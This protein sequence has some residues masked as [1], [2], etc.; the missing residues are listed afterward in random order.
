MM[1][2]CRSRNDGRRC[3]RELDHRGLHRHRMIMWT[4]AGA[5]DPRCRG[6]G[7]RGTVA[8][9][10]SNGFPGGRAVCPDCLG[11]VALGADG[12]LV[13]H[14]TAS[15]ASEEEAVERAEWFNTHGWTESGTGP[16]RQPL[17]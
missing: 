15:A 6:S 3:T 9:T 13:A 2:F 12:R 7:S 11:F 16:R 17:L 14:D 4:D 8:P 10:S 5:D 1:Q